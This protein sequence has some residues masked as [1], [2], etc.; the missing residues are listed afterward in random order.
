MFVKRAASFLLM[1]MVFVGVASAQVQMGGV[2]LT[3]ADGTVIDP[4]TDVDTNVGG[5]INLRNDGPVAVILRFYDKNGN[6]VSEVGLTNP[7]NDNVTLPAGF[8]KGDYVIKGR[9]AGTPLNQEV[10]IGELH[11]H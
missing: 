3:K 6:L 11:V 2:N 10:Q 5:V 7:Y 1:L 8:V 4:G 9:A